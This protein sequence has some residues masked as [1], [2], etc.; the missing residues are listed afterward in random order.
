M[1]CIHQ[2]TDAF[3]LRPVQHLY[4]LFEQYDT[5]LKLCCDRASL[6]AHSSD[7][8]N[9]VYYFAVYHCTD[10]F[11]YS[12][13]KSQVNKLKEP[14]CFQL[15]F[16][17]EASSQLTVTVKLITK[18]LEKEK[19]S[20]DLVCICFCFNLKPL[21]YICLWEC[22]PAKTFLQRSKSSFTD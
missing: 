14:L 1:D 12:L 7:Q 6:P 2:K 17:V 16:T 22:N 3:I 9:H 11:S 4:F 21:W 20:N 8:L 18:D 5:L 13:L 15:C 19:L 10:C